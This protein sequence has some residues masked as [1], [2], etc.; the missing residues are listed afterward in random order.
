[1][2]LVF[3]KEKFKEIKEI[4]KEINKNTIKNQSRNE[5]C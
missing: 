3:G 5:R 4:E 1:M 2:D